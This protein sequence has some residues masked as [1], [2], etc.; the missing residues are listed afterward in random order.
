M[1]ADDASMMSAAGFYPRTWTF[2]DR[3][4]A[5][6]TLAAALSRLEIPDNTR[7]LAL[8]RGGVPV[9]FEI[10]KSLHL[11][12]HVMVVRK[13][14]M[15]GQPELAIGA[16]GSGGVVVREP[17]LEGQLRL[18]GISWDELVRAER[19]ELERRER[20]YRSD[21]GAPDLAGCTALLV[22]DGLATG[23]TMLAAIRAARGA[24]AAKVI[25][26]APVASVEAEAAI[27]QEAD[28]T[29]FLKVPSGLGSIGKWYDCFPQ[30]ADEEVCELLQTAAANARAFRKRARSKRN[31]S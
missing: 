20:V 1:F 5:G 19:H 4:S 10:A 18:A 3:R 25:A 28:Q 12:L 21:A 26:V 15:P 29:L 24:G 14:G 2:P 30:L 23:A 11:P 31:P 7:V 13:I 16:I 17:A 9:G 27:G 8:P 22:D 6:I